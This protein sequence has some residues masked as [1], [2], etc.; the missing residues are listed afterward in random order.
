MTYATLLSKEIRTTIATY[1]QNTKQSEKSTTI[2][3]DEY[4]C[5]VHKSPSQLNDNHI[6]DQITT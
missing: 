2:P 5:V 1:L 3:K 4:Y 6:Y